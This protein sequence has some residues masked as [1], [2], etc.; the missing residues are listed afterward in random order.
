MTDQ[1]DLRARIA[2]L[3]SELEAE[4]RKNARLESEKAALLELSEDLA[5]QI[6]QICDYCG[7]PIGHST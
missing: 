2:E 1:S 7:R 3:E 5:S 4:R 6:P